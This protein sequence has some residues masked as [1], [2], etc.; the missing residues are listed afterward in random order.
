MPIRISA[1]PLSL[2]EPEAALP[3]HLGRLLGLAPAALT[4]WRIL[5]KS[6]DARD[7]SSLRFYYTVEVTLPADEERIVA[8][9][10]PAVRAGLRV[11]L[12]G[13]PPFVLPEPGSRP[14]PHRPV[15]IGSGP[16]GLAAAYFLATQGYRP[17]VLE[18]G[19]R[20]RERIHDV[21]AF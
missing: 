2:D 14:L 6:L 18:R 19:R 11:E 15:V 4:C 10:H 3:E 21:H 9:A 17:L 16:A 1:V 20:V 12:R 7:K 13:E 5:R 8:Q